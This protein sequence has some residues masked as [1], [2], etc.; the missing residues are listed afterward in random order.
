M[1]RRRCVVVRRVRAGSGVRHG[2]LK[3]G[4]DL[5]P[6]DWESIKEQWRSNVEFDPYESEV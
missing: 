2:D 1:A 3:F 6:D 4:P 5:S